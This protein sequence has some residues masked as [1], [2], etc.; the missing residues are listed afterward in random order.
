MVPYVIIRRLN[1]EQLFTQS[2]NYVVKAPNT[3]PL[4]FAVRLADARAYAIEQLLL[5]RK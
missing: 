5:L 4:G 2:H 3:Q 1:P